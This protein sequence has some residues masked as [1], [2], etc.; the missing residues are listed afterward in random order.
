M[1]VL[2]HK[3]WLGDGWQHGLRLGL[4]NAYLLMLMLAQ[5]QLLMLLMVLLGE[6][7]LNRPIVALDQGRWVLL[8][9]EAR[10]GALTAL[11][12]LILS[13]SDYC[14][15]AIVVIAKGVLHHT[16]RLL[17]PGDLLLVLLVVG[18][19]MGEERFVNLK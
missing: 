9:P 18:G 11:T 13:R 10:A 7:G 17:S 15:D 2:Q 1:A 19:S 6:E 4:T 12:S 16:H 8:L 3:V 14:S 5:R